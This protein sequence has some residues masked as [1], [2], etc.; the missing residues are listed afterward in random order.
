MNK[1]P[2]GQKTLRTFGHISLFPAAHYAGIV[3]PRPPS[4]HNE[5]SSPAGACSPIIHHHPLATSQPAPP[6]PRMFVCWIVHSLAT[7]FKLSCTLLQSWHQ[8]AAVAPTYRGRCFYFKPS[9]SHHSLC[10]AP[11][12]FQRGN[13]ALSLFSLDIAIALVTKRTLHAG[14]MGSELQ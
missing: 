11:W 1:R 4:K 7:M 10:V 3:A 12:L 9:T 5:S 14:R 8:R 6:R 2:P 13:Q